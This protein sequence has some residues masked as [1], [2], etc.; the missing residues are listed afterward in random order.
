M[1]LRWWSQTY[2]PQSHFVHQLSA[3]D[4][5]GGVAYNNYSNLINVTGEA[6]KIRVKDH[7]EVTCA[8]VNEEI[9]SGNNAPKYLMPSAI[10]RKR[11]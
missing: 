3:C 9:K 10:P 2:S 5:S 4:F 6:R 1:Y 7:R 8:T 11:S